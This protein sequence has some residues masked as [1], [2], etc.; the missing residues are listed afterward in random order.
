MDQS[1]QERQSLSEAPEKIR[2]RR[3]TVA[4]KLAIVRECLVPGASL[5][6]VAMAHQTN[7]NMVRKPAV[8]SVP[9]QVGVAS[10]TLEIEGPWGVVRFYG[11]P[12][13]E[14]VKPFVGELSLKKHLASD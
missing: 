1:K 4:Q 3:Y 7:A 8:V 12:D 11:P 5:A 2:R 6:G 9:A 14:L 10:V 13:P